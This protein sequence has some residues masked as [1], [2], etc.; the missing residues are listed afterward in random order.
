MHGSKVVHGLRG[1]DYDDVDA[2]VSFDSLPRVV[3]KGA[4][5]RT[6]GRLGRGARV[7]TPPAAARVGVDGHLH[8]AAQPG[9]LPEGSTLT[10]LQGGFFAW[11]TVPEGCA[12][13]ELMDAAIDEK[14]VF[15]P[16]ASFTAPG[17]GERELRLALAF[18]SP[19]R[20]AEGLG[21]WGWRCSALLPNRVALRTIDTSA[22]SRLG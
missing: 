14:V 17:E 22:R 19:E 2:I 16:A 3:L 12:T 11:V 8:V 15:M 10:H 13:S 5:A 20:L 9:R 7:D 4:R 1:S 6:A 18:E 21:G